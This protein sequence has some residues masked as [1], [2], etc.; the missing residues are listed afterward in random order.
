[1]KIGF[2]ALK[3]IVTFNYLSKLCLNFLGKIT[4]IFENYYEVSWLKQMIFSHRNHRPGP[5]R[6]EIVS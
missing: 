2:N 5:R 1:M 4:L 3:I 6:P